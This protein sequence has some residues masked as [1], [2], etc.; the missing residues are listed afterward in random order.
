[1]A[2]LSVGVAPG[3]LVVVPSVTFIATANAVC[4]TGAEPVLVDC[5]EY[6]GIDHAVLDRF[7]RAE[8]LPDAAG[9]THRESGRR[10]SA[11]VPVHL[12]GTPVAPEVFEV[13]S[14]AGVP[15]VE[16][17]AESLGATWSAGAFAG[18]QTGTVGRA[19][20]ISFN[21]NKTI[22]CGGG[23]AILTDD[24]GI[25]TLSRRYINQFKRDDGSF[26]HDR[27]G[28]NYRLSN[29]HAALGRAQ[30]ARLDTFVAERRARNSRYAEL[31]G[32]TPGLRIVGERPGTVSSHWLPVLIVDPAEFGLSAPELRAHLAQHHIESR[33]MWPPVH[34]QP[35]YRSAR[36]LSTT[37]AAA[38]DGCVLNLPSSNTM[39]LAD[40]DRVAHAVLEAPREVGR[41]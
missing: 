2:L 5:D 24:D 9:L 37:Q 21:A 8:C 13:C 20:I 33:E 25:A 10:V 41:S 1:V 17:A 26:V 6:L 18:R 32:M 40:V 19:G 29:L 4:Y 36:M 7:F 12:F 15:V 39:L 11:V 30:L 23:G 27:V 28:Y 16:D 34:T 31:L 22:T 38:I 14:R 3:D 35:A